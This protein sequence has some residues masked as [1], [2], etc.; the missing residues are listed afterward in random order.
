MMAAAPTTIKTGK[1][2]LSWKYR[3]GSLSDSTIGLLQVISTNVKS[4][5]ES[6]SWFRRM[7]VV[8]ISRQNR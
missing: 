8:L 4:I 6:S 1:R 5:A 2:Q 3:L 7:F